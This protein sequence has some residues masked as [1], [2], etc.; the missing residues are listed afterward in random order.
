MCLIN[1]N[2][3]IKLSRPVH[4]TLNEVRLDTETKND[5]TVS[6][7]GHGFMLMWFKNDGMK[8]QRYDSTPN[9]SIAFPPC[10]LVKDDL[11]L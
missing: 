10:A 9:D 4:Y 2:Y 1:L 3:D 6:F 7:L 5:N 11:E 8:L